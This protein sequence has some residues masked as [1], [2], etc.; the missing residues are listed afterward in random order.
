MPSSHSGRS[1]DRRPSAADRANCALPPD[2]SRIADRSF[3]PRSRAVLC[4]NSPTLCTE[5]APM[6]ALNRSRSRE[7]VHSPRTR[8]DL[9]AAG[10]GGSETTRAMAG[11]FSGLLLCVIFTVAS[12]T[13]TEGRQVMEAAIPI[14]IL[15]IGLAQRTRDARR[16]SR[17]SSSPA[18]ARVRLG[19]RRRDLHP[20]RALHAS[21][22]SAP[23]ADDFHLPRR[24]LLG[25]LFLIRFGATSS[26]KR[27]A[28]THT[29]SDSDH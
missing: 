4:Q 23:G 6:D 21:A 12:A 22:S 10:H 19:R 2:P 29:R 18:S 27:M 9:Y 7:C 8:R 14:S 24:R 3:L 5:A 28:S 11:R 20:P 1:E 25:V 17:T 16:C 15:A 26:A 13:R